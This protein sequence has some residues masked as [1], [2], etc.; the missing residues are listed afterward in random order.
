[1]V[2]GRPDFPCGASRTP[3]PQKAIHFRVEFQ[4]ECRPGLTLLSSHSQNEVRVRCNQPSAIDGVFR[5]RGFRN[6]NCA[7]RVSLVSM[8]WN[9]VTRPSIQVGTLR[10]VAEDEGWTVDSHYAYLNFYALGQRMLAL[11]PDD[12]AAAYELVSE[13]LYHLSAGD[14]IFTRRHGD[15]RSRQDYF[16]LLRA[17]RVDEASIALIDGL[18]DVA[19]RHVTETA[20][21][22]LRRAPDV[23]GFTTMFSQN[24]PTLAVVERLRAEGFAGTIVLGGSNCEGSMGRAL[25]ANF[26]AVDAVVDGPG[27]EAFAALLRQV[28]AGGPVVSR[29]RL[30]TRREAEAAGGRVPVPARLE[31][32]TPNYDGF[33]EQ[34][35]DAGLADLEPSITLPV[36][37]SRG[38]WWGQR[39]HCT[40]CG[41]NGS[42]MRYRSKRPETV[43]DELSRLM[44]R[45]G[46]LDF[47]AVDNILD[48]AYLESALPLVERLGTD[49][50]L[51][52]EVKANMEWADIRRLRRAGV[53]SVQPGIESL[54]TESLRALKKGTTAFQNIRFLLGC[55]EFGVQA[56][57]NILTGYP[58]ETPA[59]IIA[60]SDLIASV[61]HLRPPHITLVRFDRFS[62]YAESP[63]SFG[64]TLSRPFPGYRHAYPG[65]SAEDL[66]D[67]AY[68]F[69]GEFGDDDRNPELRRRLAARVRLWRTHHPAARFTYRLGFERVNLHDR[70]PGLP[71]Q[72]TT[73]TGDEARL[74][75]ACIGG[76][77]FRDLKAQG[78]DGPRWE[79]AWETLRTWQRRRWV[80]VEG[81]KA[82]ALA[83]RR[84][85]SAHRSE[86]ADGAVRRA[87][88]P[89]PLTV[90]DRKRKG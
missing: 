61:S 50:S 80:L 23:I 27:E 89:L 33:F 51:F 49:H 59:S 84:E 64:L 71:E 69:E 32:P 88:M 56:D 3:L 60:Q 2:T 46:V 31:V 45:Y 79:S 82:I 10:S 53:R 21:E 25:L 4:F 81:T 43:A 48:L 7:A 36:E 14:W 12:W 66:W 18:R 90:A 20:A 39:T 67:I 6:V 85:P 63:E 11:N 76:T 35:R 65:M 42:T 86:P 13:K 34:L 24:G 9:S 41:L 74:F 5:V 87:R 29:G 78:W 52:F 8:P 83:I 19:E 38:C 54:S 37:F 55:A 22:L 17:K 47:F 62:P 26:P 77:R 58:G 30:V 70:R 28:A 1:M 15:S 40:F 16:A 44:S 72:H 73:L 57:W 68:H 75:R